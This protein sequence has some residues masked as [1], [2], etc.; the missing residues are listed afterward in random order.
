MKKKR[1]LLFVNTLI[2]IFIF[3]GCS[4]NTE[5][6]KEI[7]PLTGEERSELIQTALNTD[8]MKILLEERESCRI[9]LYWALLQPH[10]VG[11]G[12]T[13]RGHFNLEF[14]EDPEE[15]E[16]F[17]EALAEGAEIYISVRIE[18]GDPVDVRLDVDINPDSMKVVDIDHYS[19]KAPLE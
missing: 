19:I 9:T 8:N 10:D 4:E 12:Y 11:K 18:A 13:K 2:F 16:R 7:R 3:T 5:G 14:E 17:E 15:L 1:L 6:I